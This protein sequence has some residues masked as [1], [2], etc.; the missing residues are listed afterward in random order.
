[1]KI[2]DMNT[3]VNSSCACARRAL[4]QTPPYLWHL[5]HVY[6]TYVRICIYILHYEI[7]LTIYNV[8]YQYLICMQKFNCIKENRIGMK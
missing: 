4:K 7:F 8:S 1:M 2:E 3:V 6:N 5:Y